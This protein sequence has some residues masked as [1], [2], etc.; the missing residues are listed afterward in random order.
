M[1]NSTVQN[2]LHTG[3]VARDD[4]PSQ[5]EAQTVGGIVGQADG[6]T[7]SHAVWKAG[8]VTQGCSPTF[9]AHA[10]GEVQNNTAVEDDADGTDEGH[11]AA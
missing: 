6:G 4:Q 9:I 1:K 3:T 5:D 11:E 2:A 7:V 10:V 8:S